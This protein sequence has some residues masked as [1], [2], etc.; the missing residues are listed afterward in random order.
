MTT[1]IPPKRNIFAIC[2]NKGGVGKT[3][4]SVNLAAALAEAGYSV[5]FVD[6]DGQGNASRMFG[7]DPDTEIKNMHTTAEAL[8]LDDPVALAD[9]RLVPRWDEEWASQI[10]FVPGKDSLTLRNVEAGSKGAHL[11]LRRIL[12]PLAELYDFVL[13]D[14]A[15]ALDHI[16]HMALVAAHHGVGVTE[17]RKD[18]VLGVRRLHSFIV[19][20][21]TREELHLDCDLL[22]VIINKH[23]TG[24]ASEKKIITQIT[25]S[26]GDRVW[27]PVITLR[28]PIADASELDN[29]PQH[30][31]DAEVRALMQAA[32]KSFVARMELAVAA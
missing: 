28:S 7:Y 13:I 15:P 16:V 25:D 27:T 31:V 21:D 26:W 19:D 17:P 1:L 14:C 6:L 11:R 24:V 29:P 22:A 30:I 32:L 4:T 9:I 5:L 18:S 3:T 23:R 8:R 20:P 12:R 2:N 10:H